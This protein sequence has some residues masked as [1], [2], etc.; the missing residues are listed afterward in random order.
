MPDSSA[1]CAAE[2]VAF[3]TTVVRSGEMPASVACC[4]L[5]G[6]CPKNG[7][8]PVSLTGS[9][10]SL[11]PSTTYHYRLVATDASGTSYGYDFTL[12][13]APGNAITPPK[14]KLVNVARSRPAR[15]NSQN[16]GLFGP[17]TLR[18]KGRTL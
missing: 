16:P 17:A 9:L 6:V 4:T 18:T 8:L 2:S 12:T 15:P 10:G 11:V 7:A 5:A 3:M 1:A 13:T 14:S